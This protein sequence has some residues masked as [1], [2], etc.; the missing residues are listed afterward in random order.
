MTIMK[1]VKKFL[2]KHSNILYSIL[3]AV[4]IVC[5]VIFSTHDYLVSVR[6]TNLVVNALQIYVAVVPSFGIYYFFGE[7]RIYKGVYPISFENSPI[8]D[9][10]LLKQ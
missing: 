6:T 3:S 7:Y 5:W 8:L 4:L 9:D 2:I 1:I 10:F